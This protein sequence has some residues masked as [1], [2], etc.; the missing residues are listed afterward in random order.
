MPAHPY[1]ALGAHAGAPL[2]RVAV[3]LFGGADGRIWMAPA[4]PFRQL[5]RCVNYC[6]LLVP[7]FTNAR[8][9]QAITD[10]H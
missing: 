4:Y 1:L 3:P 8:V 10:P 6:T 7:K 5:T 2:Y 9:L